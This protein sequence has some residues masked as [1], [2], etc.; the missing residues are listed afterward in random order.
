[1][2]TNT[3]AWYPPLVITIRWGGHRLRQR[4]A[5]HMGFGEA[6]YGDRGSAMHT[7]SAAAFDAM[8]GLSC[9]A[10]STRGGT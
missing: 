9:A 10:M 2:E 1:M 3:E 5:Q 7:D 4:G 8:V 6:Q